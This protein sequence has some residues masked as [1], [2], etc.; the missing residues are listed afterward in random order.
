MTPSDDGSLVID[1][2]AK[3]PDLSVVGSGDG[4]QGA[5]STQGQNGADDDCHRNRP[6]TMG[7]RHGADR[8]GHYPLHRGTLGP[9]VPVPTVD[10]GNRY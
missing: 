10:F 4:Y 8:R 9:L 1:I 7:G 5:G 2:F 3:S 6:A